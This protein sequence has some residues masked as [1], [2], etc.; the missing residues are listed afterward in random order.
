MLEL[1]KYDISIQIRSGYWTVYGILGLTYI[2]LLINLPVLIRQDVIVY[3]IFSDTSVLGLI[4][5]GALILFEKQQ[6]VLQ[7]FSVT[8]LDLRTYLF[9]KALSVTILSTLISLLIWMVPLGS[10]RGAILIFLEVVLSSVVF[11]LFGAG[12]T[13]G[14]GSF[15]QFLARVVVGSLIITIPV[16][17]ML[18]LPYTGWLVIFPANASLDLLLKAAEGG[19]TLI[20]VIDILVLTVWVFIMSRFAQREFKKHSLFM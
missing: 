18:F 9:S 6:G 15:N 7:S 2:L 11:T 16:F 19:I 1:F 3:I 4:F 10:F 12:F 5:V 20:Q 8:P 13:A 17:P 14:A